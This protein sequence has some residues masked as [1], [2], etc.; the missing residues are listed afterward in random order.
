MKSRKELSIR[1]YGLNHF[2][3]WTDIRDKDGND[4][5]PAIQKHVKEHGY[6][7]PAE[8]E[9]KGR[10]GSGSKLGAHIRKSQRSLSIG[11]KNLAEYLFEVLLIP[12]R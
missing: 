4:L 11:S 10:R 1:Y 7:T 8:L 9:G 12:A 5:M 2:G 3:W 6:I